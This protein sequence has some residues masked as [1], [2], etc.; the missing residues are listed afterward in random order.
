[1]PPIGLQMLVERT[2]V[3]I[4]MLVTVSFH[5]VE[6]QI[7]RP[8]RPTAFFLAFDLTGRIE[9]YHEPNILKAEAGVPRLECA[10]SEPPEKSNVNLVKITIAMQYLKRPAHEFRA[11]RRWTSVNLRK[12]GLAAHEESL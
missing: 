1:M 5:V 3:R 6:K 2:I 10:E 12:Q 8:G 11:I 9:M 7:I 4:R